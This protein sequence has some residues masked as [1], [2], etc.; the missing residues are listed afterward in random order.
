MNEHDKERIKQLL[1]KSLPPISA[2]VGT[3]LRSDLWPAML[4]RLE[5]RPP[6][7]PWFDWALLAA[8]A[9]WLVFFPGAIPV[10]VYHL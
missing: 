8:V 9:A 7:I 6:A 2:R 10:L 3:E 1:E 4:Q 5:E